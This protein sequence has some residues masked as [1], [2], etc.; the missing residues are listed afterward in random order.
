M[1]GNT[2]TTYVA[3][4]FGPNDWDVF[5]VEADGARIWSEAEAK[6]IL[7]A[8]NSVAEGWRI[9]KG[10]RTENYDLGIVTDQVQWYDGPTDGIAP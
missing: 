9:G 8:L 6:I 1:K 4:S 10:T 3:Q 7:F 5:A 2:M